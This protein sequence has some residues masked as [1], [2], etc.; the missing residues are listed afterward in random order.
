MQLS[1]LANISSKVMR[2]AQLGTYNYADTLRGWQ[3]GLAN[4]CMEHPHGV[5]LGLVNYSRD[6]VAHKI[7]LVNI[8]PRRR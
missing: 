4:V 6:T 8:N 2:G 5:Q 7:G 3:I 1:V